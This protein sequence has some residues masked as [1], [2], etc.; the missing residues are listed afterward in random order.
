VV[1]PEDKCVMSANISRSNNAWTDATL[2]VHKSA[3]TLSMA[4]PILV[5]IADSGQEYAN[6]IKSEDSIHPFT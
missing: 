5:T 3:I 2:L 4:D 1:Q 6:H